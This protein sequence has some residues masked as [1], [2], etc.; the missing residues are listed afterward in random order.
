MQTFLFCLITYCQSNNNLNLIK[1]LTIWTYHMPVL[2]LKNENQVT[3]MSQFFN[4][5][6]T[7][8]QNMEHHH[9]QA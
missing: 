9:Q 3:E 4:S 1:S 7:I 6:L 2:K 5:K 8:H